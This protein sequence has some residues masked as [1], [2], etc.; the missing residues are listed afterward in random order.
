M[1]SHVTS[2]P[3]SETQFLDVICSCVFLGIAQ[4]FIA[5]WLT[6]FPIAFE[7]VPMEQPL[8]GA[9]QVESF[10]SRRRAPKRG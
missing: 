9:P 6:E 2:V 3:V 7:T 1:R 4:R 8:R 10:T 5:Y